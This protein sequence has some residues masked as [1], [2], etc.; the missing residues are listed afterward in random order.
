M[1]LQKICC[2]N[3]NWGTW[4]SDQN[5]M[6]WVTKKGTNGMLKLLLKACAPKAIGNSLMTLG[7]VTTDANSGV[8]YEQQQQ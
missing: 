3:F 8:K 5:L 4:G 7:Y 1:E 6:M 2:S